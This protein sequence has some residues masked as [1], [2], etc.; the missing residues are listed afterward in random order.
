MN[1]VT[2]NLKKISD[3]PG[4]V[5]YKVYTT[6]LKFCVAEVS[7]AV[8]AS[9][10]RYHKVKPRTHRNPFLLLLTLVKDYSI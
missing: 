4:T 8:A 3:C 10:L 2:K 5:E 1:C 6:W 9:V 7:T